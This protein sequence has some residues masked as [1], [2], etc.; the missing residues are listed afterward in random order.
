M[1]NATVIAG[2]EAELLKKL[3]AIRRRGEKITKA[4]FCRKVGYANKSALRHFPVLRREL[5][6]YVGSFNKQGSKNSPSTIRL[7]LLENKHLTRTCEKQEQEIRKIPVLEEK[8]VELT[9]E[10]KRRGNISARLRGMVSA[11]ISHFIGH[12]LTGAREI[13]AQLEELT[14]SILAE[15]EEGCSQ[16]VDE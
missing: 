6:L 11:L 3:E 15:T 16:E 5:D 12:D 14:K 4:E 8:V 7:L 9:A 1:E 13:S 10:I 2:R